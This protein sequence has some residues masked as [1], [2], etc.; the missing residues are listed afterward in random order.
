MKKFKNIKTSTSSQYDTK[1]VENIHMLKKG[2]YSEPPYS[3]MK[4]G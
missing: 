1:I 2:N 3:K 4:S